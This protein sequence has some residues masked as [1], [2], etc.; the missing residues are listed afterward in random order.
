MTAQRVRFHPATA[1]QRRPSQGLAGLGNLYQVGSE[2]KPSYTYKVMT[3]GEVASAIGVPLPK[4]ANPNVPTSKLG[5]PFLKVYNA[6]T[7]AFVGYIEPNSVGLKAVNPQTLAVDPSQVTPIPI[8]AS[9]KGWGQSNPNFWKTVAGAGLL[10][11]AVVTAGA[12]LAPAAASTGTT[13]ATGISAQSAVTNAATAAANAAAGAAPAVGT[14]TVLA[15]AVGTGTV[16]A[17]TVATGAASVLPTVASVTAPAV[18][19]GA[20]ST[21]ATVAAAAAP[22]AS[23]VPA[24][25]SGL[26]SL[27]Q[28]GTAIAPA[29]VQAITGGAGSSTSTPAPVAKS[30]LPAWLLP[31]G[32]GLGALFLLLNH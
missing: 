29:A 15:P 21:A 14:G 7:G 11:A 31:V 18:T 3:S 16:L 22:A 32:A 28:A 26:T 30:A 23:A 4:G 5:A 19:G 12:A 17:P 2:T 1:M 27:L 24:A 8:F 6:N 10:F 20:G 13:A 25:A 9:L